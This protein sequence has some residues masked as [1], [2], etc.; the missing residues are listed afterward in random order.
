MRQD[1]ELKEHLKDQLAEEPV[2]KIRVP[3]YIAA[4]ALERDGRTY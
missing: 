4:S 3:K 1:A 2:T